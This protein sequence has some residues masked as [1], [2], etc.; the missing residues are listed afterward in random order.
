MVSAPPL[1]G[2]SVIFTFNARRWW[3]LSARL[4]LALSFTEK[5]R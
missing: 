4:A 3:R 1:T 2:V 5:D